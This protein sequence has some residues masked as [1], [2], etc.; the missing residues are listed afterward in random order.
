MP[1]LD[2]ELTTLDYSVQH[3]A[4]HCHMPCIAQTTNYRY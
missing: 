4:N 2:I 3:Q 1:G